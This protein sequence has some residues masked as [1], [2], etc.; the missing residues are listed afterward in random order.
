MPRLAI[1][2]V[3][4][5]PLGK[6]WLTE[7]DRGQDVRQLQ[8]LLAELGLYAGAVNGEY[9]LLTQEA[10]KCFQ[11]AYRLAVDGVCGP[12]TCKLL[13]E[14][15]IHN[16]LLCLCDEGATLQTLAEKYGVSWQALKDP[17]TRRRL[18]RVIPGQQVMV[19]RRELIFTVETCSLPEELGLEAPEGKTLFCVKP[20]MLTE[21]TAGFSL[22]Q[23][24]SLVV[25]LAASNLS[26]RERKALL[27]LRRVVNTELIW[28]QHL[29]NTRLPSTEEADALII[30]VPVS[31][32]VA[33]KPT[34]WLRRIKKFLT[35]YPCTRLFT[36]FDLTG[37]VR[38][39]QGNEHYLTPV[40]RK[41]A[42]LNRIGEPKRIGRYGWVAY[43]YQDQDAIKTVFVPDRLTIRGILDQ[44]DRLNLRGAVFTGLDRWWEV[45]RA[46]GNRYFLATPRIMVMRKGSLA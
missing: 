1:L 25:D 39:E 6:R 41:L 45:W 2:S 26:R 30:S 5:L 21:L 32:L 9:D 46:E 10:V 37:V 12:D 11:K 4:S 42:R 8:A 3:S 27:R 36:H 34:V 18:R 33:D 43:R 44:I 14:E 16:R 24:S 17:V 38:D 13:V 7:G 20:E 19:E 15:R 28:W 31:A 35:D 40:E 29:D 22:P 23:G